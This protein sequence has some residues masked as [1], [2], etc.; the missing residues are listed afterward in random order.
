MEDNGRLTTCCDPGLSPS[1]LLQRPA[2]GQGG[3]RGRVQH[4]GGLQRKPVLVWLPRVRTAGYA[5]TLQ[6]RVLGSGPKL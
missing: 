3:V 4:G 1:D 6:L 2:A 5:H